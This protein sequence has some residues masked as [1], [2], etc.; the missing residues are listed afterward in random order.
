MQNC[1]DTGFCE[2]PAG[3]SLGAEMGSSGLPL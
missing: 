1:C 2:S 3:P